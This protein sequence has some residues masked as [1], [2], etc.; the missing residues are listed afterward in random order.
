MT[1]YAGLTPYA[2]REVLCLHCCDQPAMPS[3]MTE[4]NTAENL[5]IGPAVLGGYDC[6]SRP[7]LIASRP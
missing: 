1:P 3:G 5:K 2:G 4:E 6:P 7:D